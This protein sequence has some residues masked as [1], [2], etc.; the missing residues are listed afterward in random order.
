MTQMHALVAPSSASARLV[1]LIG[2]GGVGKTR[3]A[4]S[5]AESLDRLY[6]DGGAFVGLA[7]LSD[8]RLIS[9]TIARGL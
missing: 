5:V 9:A 8:A 3:L 2:P 4:A 6:A 7:P 1:T